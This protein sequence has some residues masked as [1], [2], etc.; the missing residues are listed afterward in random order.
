VLGVSQ[1][2]RVRTLMYREGGMETAGPEVNGEHLWLKSTWGLDG[3]SQYGYSTDG[4]TFLA[5]GKAYQLGWGY[6]RGDRVGVYSF[7]DRG[8]EGYVDVD[9]FRH[10]LTGPGK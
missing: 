2:G 5:L 10:T 3:V 7:N 9:W 8:E 1:R 6:Y 4:R